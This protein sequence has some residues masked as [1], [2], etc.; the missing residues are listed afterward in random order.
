MVLNCPWV[1]GKIYFLHTLNLSVML[2]DFC[3]FV[4]KFYELIALTFD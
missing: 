1:S 2:Q 4:G 3:L